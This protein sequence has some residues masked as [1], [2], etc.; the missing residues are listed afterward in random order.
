MWP[1][2]FDYVY[3]QDKSTVVDKPRQL[4]LV[5][6]CCG[7]PHE[8][9]HAHSHACRLGL[10]PAPVKSQCLEHW[11]TDELP[12]K[13]TNRELD[14][15]KCSLHSTFPPAEGCPKQCVEF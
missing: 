3:E 1:V 6:C 5:S 9:A 14:C 13:Q 11:T 15:C 8:T 7:S 4:W 10:T 2:S 12:V